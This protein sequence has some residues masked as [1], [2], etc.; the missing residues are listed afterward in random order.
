M[1][2]LLYWLISKRHTFKTET[3]GLENI[4]Y[5]FF[6]EEECTEEDWEWYGDGCEGQCG[7][8]SAS[9]TRICNGEVEWGWAECPECD[10][11]QNN[12][13]SL[14]DNGSLMKCEMDT[15]QETILKV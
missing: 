12:N 14:I 10:N 11:L 1:N 5:L 4:K 3:L 8:G 15:A 7:T 6:L 9:R 2:I 13:D